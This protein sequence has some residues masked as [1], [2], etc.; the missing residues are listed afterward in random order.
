MRRDRCFRTGKL[1]QIRHYTLTFLPLTLQLFLD[2]P[3]FPEE[4]FVVAYL[5][6]LDGKLAELW[7]PRPIRKSGWF[8]WRVCVIFKKSQKVWVLLSHSS[9]VHCRVLQ[10]VTVCCCELQ[11]V[12]VCCSVLQCVA[13]WWHA[14]HRE[15]LDLYVCVCRWVCCRH[16]VTIQFTIIDAPQNEV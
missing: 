4:K 11:C 16:V 13:V 3:P 7:Y 15:R 12:A 2:F 8:T 1:G 14:S 5:D 9:E 6:I 10:C